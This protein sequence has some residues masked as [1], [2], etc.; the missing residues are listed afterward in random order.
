MSYRD[1]DAMNQSLLKKILVHPKEF[2]R[3]KQRIMEENDDSKIE[4]WFIFGSLVDHMLTED[5]PVEDRFYVMSTKV[6]SESIQMVVDGVFNEYNFEGS[7]D[8]KLADLSDFILKHCKY[9]G[10]QDRWK[11]ETKIAKIIELGTDYFQSLVESLGKIIVSQD[12]YAKAITCKMTLLNNNFTKKWLKA[13]SNCEV[14]KKVVLSWEE[15]D[16]SCKGELDFVHIDHEK[17]LVTPVDLKTM[18]GQ[19]YQFPYNFW[20]YRY[21]FQGAFYESGLDKSDFLEKHNIEDYRIEPMVYVVIEKDCINDPMVFSNAA[22]RDIGMDGGEWNNRTYE[23]YRQAL[24]RYKFHR[25]TDQW[26]YPQ[27]YIEADGLML[28]L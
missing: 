26:N 23:G 28:S 20:K 25:D 17:R 14:I 11:D 21:D 1:I 24:D 5:T 9:Q 13:E 8:I 15:D 4:P 19:I 10:Y 3:E 12:D 22:A 16:V 7:D 2:L 18:G 27:E 6:P